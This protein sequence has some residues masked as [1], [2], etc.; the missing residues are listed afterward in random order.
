MLR[1]FFDVVAIRRVYFATRVVG[2]TFSCLH[3][4]RGEISIRRLKWVF[5]LRG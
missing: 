5:D 2:T 1:G 4:I 3:C